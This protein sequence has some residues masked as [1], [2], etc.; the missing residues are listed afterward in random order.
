MTRRLLLGLLVVAALGAT[1]CGED[2]PFGP[3]GFETSDD[4]AATLR[5]LDAAQR[6]WT[7]RAPRDY[8][9]DFQRSCF[10]IPRWPV[11]LTVRLGRIVAV[12]RRD[13]GQ[14]VPEAE[15]ESYFSVERLFTE[16]HLAARGG[17]WEVRASFDP[18]YGYPR[19]VFVDQERLTIDEEQWYE[20]GN[21]T[22]LP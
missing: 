17:A 4:R 22:P 3:V 15:W 19:D 13:T 20:L 16:L 8:Q 9:I 12:V 11:R 14:S 5:A 18:E 10:C 6:R 21:L 2:D 7:A 1:G